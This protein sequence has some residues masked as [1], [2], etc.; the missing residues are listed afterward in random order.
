MSIVNHRRA[1]VIHQ[2]IGFEPHLLRFRPTGHLEQAGTNPDVVYLTGGMA[3][4]AVVRAH[5]DLVLGNLRY[6]DSD[7][8]ASVTEGLTIW[9]ART[10]A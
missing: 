2:L 5:L 8:F 9:S 1:P 7:H 4:S 6:V 3:R 10:Y